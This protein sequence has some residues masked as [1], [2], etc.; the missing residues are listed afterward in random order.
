[1][2]R[3]DMKVKFCNNNGASVHSKRV[4]IFDTKKDIGLEDSEWRDMSED[5]KLKMVEEWAFQDFNWW[6]EEVEE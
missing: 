3:I 4:E 1:M 6:Y 5:E 2:D